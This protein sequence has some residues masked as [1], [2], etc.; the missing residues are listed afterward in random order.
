DQ[1]PEE[2]FVAGA[3]AL[4]PVLQTVASDAVALNEAIS[5]ILK[6]SLMRRDR[7]TKMLEIHR[8]VQAVLRQ[9]MDESLQRIW[10]E[11]TVRAVN[12]AFPAVE[13]SNWSA[14]ERLLPQASV[15]AQLISELDLRFE[16]AARLLNQTGFYLYERARYN[17]AEPLHQ[18]A[19]AIYEQ[20]LGP[21]HPSVTLSLNNLAALYYAQSQYAQAE[22]LYQRALTILE[23]ALGPEH[24]NVATCLENYAELLTETGRTEL[25]DQFRQRAAAI[26]AKLAAD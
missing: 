26:R 23:K 16:E 21:D 14:C 2:L 22:P 12:L 11:R 5:E 13:F 18:R 8:L 7:G 9:E 6:Y 4:G 19:L 25:A 24:P 20:A 10:V 3:A 15:C 1:S 17:K